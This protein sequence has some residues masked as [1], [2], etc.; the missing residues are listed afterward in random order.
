MTNSQWIKCPI[1]GAKT[2]VKI[3]PTTIMKDFPLFC[4]HCKKEI[5]TN[6]AKM[7]IFSRINDKR[8]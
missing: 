6:V 7:K 8:S 1:C 3:L 4:H 5:I 2:R